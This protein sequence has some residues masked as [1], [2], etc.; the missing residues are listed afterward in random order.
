MVF[1]YHELKMTSRPKTVEISMFVYCAFSAH[2]EGDD[3][4]EYILLGICTTIESCSKVIDPDYEKLIHTGWNRWDLVHPLMSK[5]NK[6]TY[7]GKRTDCH[8]YCSY[9]NRGGY[10]IEQ[11]EVIE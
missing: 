10:V 1:W 9:N 5:T 4:T 3:Y 2:G 11:T 8:G 6:Y 7:I